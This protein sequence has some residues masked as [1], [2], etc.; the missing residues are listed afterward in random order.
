MKR[1][2]HFLPILST[3]LAGT[4]L[5]SCSAITQPAQSE[6]TVQT[7]SAET[8]APAW[9]GE[10][11]CAENGAT[12]RVVSDKNI[13]A[14]IIV[15][16]SGNVISVRTTEKGN[17]AVAESN[18]KKLEVTLSDDGLIATVTSEIPNISGK[19]TSDSESDEENSSVLGIS[20]V[21]VSPENPF[22]SDA[23]KLENG[24]AVDNKT[25]SL[26]IGSYFCEKNGVTLAVSKKSDGKLEFAFSGESPYKTDV[27]AYRAED[28]SFYLEGEI[29]AVYMQITEE[30]A[31]NVFVL[32]TM[33]PELSGT[34]TQ[35]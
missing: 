13:V 20:S 16:K 26:W 27:Y 5:A 3:V 28:N 34:Y 4:L 7:V 11:S 30:S 21:D 25:E 14:V 12:L 17:T 18:G 19:Y 33:H 24:D 6:Q 15:E 29:T 31:P 22:P 9:N 23:D 2:V 35:T 1:G 10:Y 8:T 32:T